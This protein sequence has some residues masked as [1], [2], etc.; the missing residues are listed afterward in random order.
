LLGVSNLSQLAPAGTQ[1][2]RVRE[3]KMTLPVDTDE[4]TERNARRAGDDLVDP[5][6][7]WQFWKRTDFDKLSYGLLLNFATLWNVMSPGDAVRLQR[8]D[9]EETERANVADHCW[10]HLCV[11]RIRSGFNW[12]TPDGPAKDGSSF[13]K[14]IEWFR[15]DG[16]DETILDSP[17]SAAA[18]GMTSR[19]ETPAKFRKQKPASK[20]SQ[21]VYSSKAADATGGAVVSALKKKSL[22]FDDEADDDSKSAIAHKRS[23]A[24]ES[25]KREFLRRSREATKDK[26]R[27]SQAAQSNGG[28]AGAA[29]SAS[30]HTAA[31]QPNGGVA[32]AA[33]SNSFLALAAQLNSGAA[34]ASQNASGGAAQAGAG[35]HSVPISVQKA[36]IDLLRRLQIDEAAANLRDAKLRLFNNAQKAAREVGI[37]T[38]DGDE[39]TFREWRRKIETF[40]QDHPEVDG[41]TLKKCLLRTWIRGKVRRRAREEDWDQ[42]D[43]DEIL[44]EIAQYY[45]GDANPEAILD[46]MKRFRV[47]NWHSARDISANFRTILAK[48]RDESEYAISLRDTRAINRLQTDEQLKPYLTDRLPLQ[49][50]QYLLINGFGN[51]LNDV[52]DGLMQMHRELVESGLW[53]PRRR[54]RFGG[55]GGRRP[56]S[57]RQQRRRGDG[58]ERRDYKS[59]RGPKRTRDSGGAPR[60]ER[61]PIE[62]DGRKLCFA[63]QTYPEDGHMA[64]DCPNK[65]REDDTSKRGGDKPRREGESSRRSGDYSQ[66]RNN[67]DRRKQH[68]KTVNVVGKRV[69]SHESDEDDLVTETGLCLPLTREVMATDT[70]QPSE[71]E[72]SADDDE[73]IKLT[74][75]YRQE[76]CEGWINALCD[77][78]SFITLLNASLVPRLQLQVTKGPKKVFR[79]ANKPLHLERYV[80]LSIA[81]VKDNK[82]EAARRATKRVSLRAYVVEDLN[83]PFLL[84]RV[85]LRKLGINPPRWQDGTRI[86]EADAKT[87]ALPRYPGDSYLYKHLDYGYPLADEVDTNSCVECHKDCALEPQQKNRSETKCEIIAKQ[88][89]NK[90]NNNSLDDV[91]KSTATKRKNQWKLKANAAVARKKTPAA[92]PKRKTSTMANKQSSA[93]K[94]EQSAAEEAPFVRQLS[95][96]RSWT[97]WFYASSCC[98]HCLHLTDHDVR[99][100]LHDDEET[101]CRSRK[102]KKD[103]MKSC[104]KMAPDKRVKFYI[105]WFNKYGMKHALRDEVASI[106]PK[107]EEKRKLEIIEPNSSGPLAL[108][109]KTHG[110]QAMQ[111][112]PEEDFVATHLAQTSHGCFVLT[113]R[114]PTRAC[115]NKPNEE[116]STEATT[117]EVQYGKKLPENQVTQFLE[118]AEEFTDIYAKD[119]FNIARLPADLE[120]VEFKIKEGAKLPRARAYRLNTAGRTEVESQV[121]QLLTAG[122]ITSSHYRALKS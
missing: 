105:N 34:G 49:M 71:D 109:N 40:R 18:A 45:Q 74:I 51:T 43:V 70:L 82:K 65:R 26:W 108:T 8:G 39:S 2:V 20:S 16:L 50:K 41:D 80:E 104:F 84:G 36:E 99:C 12:S 11:Q 5:A 33:Q 120:R 67:G 66:R 90:E 107:T 106:S 24:Y 73:P 118:L 37:R 14:A 95:D 44:S 48:Y 21:Y 25:A 89:I 102:A 64:R 98:M 31:A 93:A 110:A 7:C 86:V 113:N 38:F 17:Q 54:E 55:D 103:L 78:G 35:V 115:D 15:E 32:S 59:A 62:K 57:E 19:Y 27:G 53:A 114:K 23:S 30:V 88:R 56:G 68:K 9:Q 22:K 10:R 81:P 77:H 69:E 121:K 6:L 92:T 111:L 101:D 112:V 28:T 87:Y 1:P 58:D 63:C 79:Q 91:A 83:V 47:E 72:V 3:E 116:K 46:E 97:K 29:R 42:L 100:K 76:E 117:A 85:E 122:L 61:K 60:K 4:R 75:H 119:S 13:L 96:M 94:A 52:L